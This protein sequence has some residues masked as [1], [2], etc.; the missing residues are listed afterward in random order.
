MAQVIHKLRYDQPP[1]VRR[2]APTAP[3]ELEELVDQLL[4]KDPAE[5]VPTALVLSKRLQAMRHALDDPAQRIAPGTSPVPVE[6]LSSECIRRGAPR[7]T[8]HGE[9]RA[10][11][12]HPLGPG[13]TQ[14]RLLRRR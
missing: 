6:A 3:L 13:L 4:R 8:P 11:G 2:F 1:S 7:Y 5:R 9:S 14:L 12:R 10:R